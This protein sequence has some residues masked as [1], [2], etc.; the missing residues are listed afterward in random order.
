LNIVAAFE[1]PWPNARLMVTMM[2]VRS[3]SR[4]VRWN[5]STAGLRKRQIAQPVENDE[6]HAGQMLGEPSLRLQ[7]AQLHRDA[8]ASSNTSDAWQTL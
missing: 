6:V 5:R 7:T 4:L 1:S 8:S 3:L 2:E